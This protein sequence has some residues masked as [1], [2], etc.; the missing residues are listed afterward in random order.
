MYFNFRLRDAGVRRAFAP[1][2]VVRWRLRPD[3]PRTLQQYFRYSK[4]DALG[5]MY[6]ERHAMRFL[7][8]LALAVL[9]PASRRRRG[10]LPVAVLAGLNRMLPAYCRAFRRL[11][12]GG[13]GAAL[14]MLPVLE[15]LLDL[16]KMAGFVAGLSAASARARVKVQ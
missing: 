9:L 3:L 6:P 2:A 10:L 11:T 13:A 4:G 8:Y 7:T 15:L 1:R 14:V 12:P 16:A 5:G